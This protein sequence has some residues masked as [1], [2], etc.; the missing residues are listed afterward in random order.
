MCILQ[1]I[2]VRDLSA[3]RHMEFLTQSDVYRCTAIRYLESVVKNGRYDKSIGHFFVAFW[4][5]KHVLQ[6]L[7]Y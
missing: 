7:S 5:K 1:V 6:E 2:Q 3:L 4:F